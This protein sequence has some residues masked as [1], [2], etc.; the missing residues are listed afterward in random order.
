MSATQSIVILQHDA[1]VPAGKILT[2]LPDAQVVYLGDHPT[3][4]ADLLERY[5]TWEAQGR[6]GVNPLPDGLLVLG[7]EDDAY[8]TAKPWYEPLREILG[9]Y[10]QENRPCLGICLGAQMMAVAGG[11]RVHV[12]AEDGPENGVTA[13]NWNA[14]GTRL[15]PGQA[16]RAYEAHYDAI[17]E[18]PAGA[19]EL[20]CS[21][22]YLQAFAWGLCLG[23]QFHPEVTY[24]IALEW[25]EQH[26]HTDTEALLSEFLRYEAEL[27]ESCALL[28]RW[29][30]KEISSRS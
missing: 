7:G 11:G 4:V 1:D 12:R 9:I 30:S 3:W 20:A 21:D 14:E 24:S 18:L 8:S 5:R 13:L 27:E 19:R 22:R 17:V 2:F 10:H 26:S 6:T 28:C 23:V 16:S 29:L 15:L 25:E